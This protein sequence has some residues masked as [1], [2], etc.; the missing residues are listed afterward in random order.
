MI[1]W[2]MRSPFVPFEIHLKDGSII[3]VDRPYLL[4]TGRNS[5][6]CVVSEG[7]DS[8][9]FIAYRDVIK[10]VAAPADES[11]LEML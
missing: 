6:S 9:R 2:R 8:V 7:A 4:A 3:C 11:L 1:E 5:A 10:V